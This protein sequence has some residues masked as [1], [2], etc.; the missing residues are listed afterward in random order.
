MTNQVTATGAKVMTPK[1][2]MSPS[3]KTL[4]HILPLLK[5]TVMTLHGW[6]QWIIQGRKNNAKRY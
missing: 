4:N 2:K 3:Q 1:A 5:M 6:T